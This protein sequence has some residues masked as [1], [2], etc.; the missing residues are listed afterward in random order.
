LKKQWCIP[1]QYSGEFVA[2]MED[3]LEVYALPYDEELPVVCM[4]EQPFQLLGE[5]L[6]PIALK[7]GK[8]RKEDYEYIR[9]GVCSIFIFTEPLAN[10]RHVHASQR[11]TKKDWAL[12]I[13]ELLEVHYPKAKRI[14][15][16]MDNLNTHAIS[17]LYETFPPEIALRLAM[18]LEIHFTPKHGS[19]LNIAE[20]ELNAMTKQC[21]D[22]RI[23]DLDSLRIELEP[24][25]QHRNAAFK[26]VD[27]HFTTDFARDKLKWLYPKLQ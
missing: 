10:W 7:P 21:L 14:R 20:I 11:R 3:V 17:S 26:S 16:V 6:Q 8:P 23:P 27:W 19:W 5:K 15:L 24:W 22:R 13:R 1:A 18:R 25:E 2:R 9:N 12:Q 4:D